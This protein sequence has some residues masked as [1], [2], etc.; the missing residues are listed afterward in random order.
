MGHLIRRADSL[1]KALMLGKT[2]AKGVDSGRGWDGS[3][4]SPTQWTWVWTNSRRR[5]RMGKPAVHRVAK[6]WTLLSN[7][8]TTTQTGCA[9]L[10]LSR[11]EERRRQVY[12][13]QSGVSTSGLVRSRGRCGAASVW[14]VTKG[15]LRGFPLRILGFCS[16]VICFPR[17]NS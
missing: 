9:W 13:L 4:A 8:A 12:Y 16:H 15:V 5:W 3:M 1:E 7:W 2:E 10:S 6:S 14:A 17:I 11:G